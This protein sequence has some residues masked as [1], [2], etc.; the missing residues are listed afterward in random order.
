MR[1]TRRTRRA[2][3]AAARIVAGLVAI[4]LLLSACTSAPPRAGPAGDVRHAADLARDAARVLLRLSAYDYALAGT[5]TGQRAYVVAPERY[6]AVVRESAAAISRFT[7]AALAAPV[8]AAGP[9]RE[10]VVVLA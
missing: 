3:S 8:D 7:A 10:R 9:L 1:K 4:A 6:A 5:L 2:S